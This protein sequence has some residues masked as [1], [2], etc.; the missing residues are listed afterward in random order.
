MDK[1]LSYPVV[2]TIAGFDGS[3]G[4]GIQGDIK[5]ISALGCYATSILTALPVQS[6]TGVESVYPIPDTVVA[7]QLT[8]ILEDITPDVI[9]IGMIHM[10]EVVAVIADALMQY[11][12]IPV[13]YDPVMVSSSGH[14]LMEEV[15]IQAIKEKLLPLVTI[16]TPNM[17]EAEV[18]TQMQVA[19]VEDMYLA[20]AKMKTLLACKS[21]LLKGGHLQ[22]EQLTSVYFAE[23]GTTEAYHSP[24]Y[25]TSNTHGTGCTLSSAIASYIAQGKNIKEAVSLGQQYVQQSIYHGMGVKTGKGKGPLNHFFGPEIMIKR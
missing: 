13:I 16:L 22:T 4:A 21:I 1:E 17:D 15:T 11:P 9:K 8:C 19:S 10:P 25:D 3:G 20:G 7:A 18:F 24:R 23:D 12:Q 6:T 2:L 5:T 14:R